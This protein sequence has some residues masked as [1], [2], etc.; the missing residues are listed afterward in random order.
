MCSPL[1]SPLS[2]AQYRR[3]VS[4]A[5]GASHGSR[6][7][8]HG[9]RGVSHGSRAES[10]ARCESADGSSTNE[11]FNETFNGTEPAS[12]PNR[13]GKYWTHRDLIAARAIELIQST[14]THH[15]ELGQAK[16]ATLI[17]Q[18]R[19]F[20]EESSTSIACHPSVSAAAKAAYSRCFQVFFP[21]WVM[22]RALLIMMITDWTN[23][24][25]LHQ[26]HSSI[27]TLFELFCGSLIQTDGWVAALGFKKGEA[28]LDQALTPLEKAISD[29]FIESNLEVVV[30][31]SEGG[32][33][34]H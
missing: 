34:M 32:P 26:H 9:S 27:P 4:E 24:D 13:H 31:A 21:S 5:S 23:L 1:I 29:R 16:D 3:P 11:T 25:E 14:L 8:S 30:A 33:Q 10:E 22:R 6:G 20:L 15:K 17:T 7:V 12:H 28:E 19:Y 2:T 18:V